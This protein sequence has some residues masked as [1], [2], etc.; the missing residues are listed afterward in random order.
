MFQCFRPTLRKLQPHS[1]YE[2]WVRDLKCLCNLKTNTILSLFLNYNLCF[3][4]VKSVEIG[5]PCHLFVF[6]GG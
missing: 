5:R 3:L 4:S 6:T 2:I 1:M